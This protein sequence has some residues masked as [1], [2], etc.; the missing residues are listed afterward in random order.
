LGATPQ[1][2][3]AASVAAGVSGLQRRRA[4]EAFDAV[5]RTGGN[6]RDPWNEEDGFQIVG[7]RRVGV[8]VVVG[9]ERIETEM[10]LAARGE[11]VRI[12]GL[13]VETAVDLRWSD[14]LDRWLAPDFDAELVEGGDA[15]FVLRSGRQTRVALH[16]PFAVDLEHMDEGGLVKAPMHGKLVAVFVAPGDHV[17]KG[18]RLA[19]VEAMKMEH[20]LTAPADGEVAEVASEPG[21]QVAEGAR[22]IVFKTEGEEGA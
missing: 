12:P 10:V 20:V 15:I 2:V 16:D 1:G 22:L 6:L 9:G 5:Q 8:P 4:D 19:I 17:K 13:E 21:A 11:V 18:Q 14:A 3:D 7:E